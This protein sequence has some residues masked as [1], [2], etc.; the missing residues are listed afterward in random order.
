MVELVISQAMNIKGLGFCFFVMLHFSGALYAASEQSQAEKAVDESEKTS[1]IVGGEF[2]GSCG[3]PSVVSVDGVCTGTLIH[4]EVV[5]TAAHCGDPSF[6]EFGDTTGTGL[7][8]GVDCIDVP[9]RGRGAD[10]QFCVLNQP[11]RS[12]PTTPILYGCELSLLRT[13]EEVTLVGYGLT[14]FQDKR[15]GGIKRWTETTI[16]GFLEE[17]STLIGTPERSPCPGDSGGPVYVDMPDGSW[18]TF[19][20]VSGGTTGTP[21][22]GDAAY[23]LIHRYVPWFESETGI[24]ITPCHDADGQWNPSPECQRFYA[25]DEEGQG[26]WSNICRGTLVSDHSQTCGIND[27]KSDDASIESSDGYGGTTPFPK[28]ETLGCAAT[29]G[30]RSSLVLTFLVLFVTCFGRMRGSLKLF[31]VP[32]LL[33]ACS[34]DSSFPIDEFEQGAPNDIGVG[35]A[36][37]SSNG[38]EPEFRY[39]DFGEVEDYLFKVANTYPQLTQLGAYG[40]A[41][42]G[43]RLYVMAISN[44]ADF[45]DD[46]TK[47]NILFNY[48][49][50]GDELITV[51]S[52]MAMIHHLVNSY[53]SDFRVTDVLNHVELFL[54]PVVSP[55]GFARQS[56]IVEGVDPNR[57]FPYPGHSSREGI[58]IIEDAKNLY[59]YFEFE[60]VLD[61]HAFG[62][63]IL[64]PFGGSFER[65]DRFAELSVLANDLASVDGYRTEQISHLLGRTALGGSNDYYYHQGA[66]A[67]GI[68]LA[69]SKVPPISN[70]FGVT[71]TATEIGLRYL[72]HFIR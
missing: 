41:P 38:L 63:L 23:P 61:F 37:S 20:V 60:G 44:N 48:S 55:D 66:L 69:Q 56:R 24:D 33:S 13:G 19:G 30:G 50:H 25:G 58:S 39:H 40:V 70:I 71:Q 47:P 28:Q 3:F 26:D 15:S 17:G 5:V 57:Q 34:D 72:E 67:V 7:I 16:Q 42:S 8:V 10:V 2:V 18:R 54:V 68:E 62:E 53:G 9:G 52:A 27:N 22:N 32:F 43:R 4:P 21:C 59:G 46:P 11:V 35:K 12:V 6:V 36:D 64:L 14:S 49:I 29:P 31:L 45:S 51:E 65:P 1:A